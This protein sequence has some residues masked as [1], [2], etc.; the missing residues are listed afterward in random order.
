MDDRQMIEA[1]EMAKSILGPSREE[2]RRGYATAALT[3]LC[4]VE[5]PMS[6][7]EAARRA[8][9]IADA[10]LEAECET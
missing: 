8:F 10:M 4:S 1:A 6:A 2:L 5:F 3:G 9:R 7:E